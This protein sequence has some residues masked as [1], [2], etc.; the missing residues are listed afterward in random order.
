MKQTTKLVI[1][2]LLLGIGL[3][4]CGGPQNNIETPKSTVMSA[5][6][7]TIAEN[8]N[9]E[10]ATIAE[11]ASTE[12]PSTESAFTESTS[13]DQS[14]SP[15]HDLWERRAETGD[16]SENILN[17]ST[18]ME[19][20]LPKEWNGKVKIS[21]GDNGDTLI[22]SEKRNEEAGAGGTLLFL[23]FVNRSAASVYPLEIFG[24]KL[25]TVLGVYQKENQEYALIR[26][27]PR[28]M[29]YKE[30]DE[31]LKQVYENTFALV[32][33]VQIITENMPGFMEC[34]IDDVSWIINYDY[35]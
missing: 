19:I 21:T 34:G 31:E 20:I 6:T 16:V 33:Q 15:T 30:G 22:I 17:Y 12:I 7:A 26:S 25:E 18:G 27:L 32:D 9:A 4:A 2:M 28:D 11:T 1:S 23:Q 5:E 14:D 3:T 13:T 8:K 35:Q 29:N 24:P 10:A